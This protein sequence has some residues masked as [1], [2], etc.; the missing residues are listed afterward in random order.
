MLTEAPPAA[1]TAGTMVT[2]VAA[3]AAAAGT[4]VSYCERPEVAPARTTGLGAGQPSAVVVD[5]LGRCAR[6]SPVA[7]GSFT[8][9]A[10]DAPGNVTVAQKHG[11][12]NVL[13]FGA[14]GDD[15]SD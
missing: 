6:Q 7:Q 9:G 2:G 14:K 3:V 8:V 13:D 4:K 11:F 12:A 5:G 15:R 1:L 10:C